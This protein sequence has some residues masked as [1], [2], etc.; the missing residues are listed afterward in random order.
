MHIRYICK[1]CIADLHITNVPYGMH[2][3]LLLDVN[4]S[5]VVYRRML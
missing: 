5:L 1:Q 3:E 4:V 2:L